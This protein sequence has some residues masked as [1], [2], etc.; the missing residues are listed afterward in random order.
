MKYKTDMSYTKIISFIIF[1]IYDFTQKLL[2]N[3]KKK[4]FKVKAFYLCG[5]KRKK[6][7]H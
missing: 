2:K 7:L 4:L 1:V 3:H 5:F 6:I